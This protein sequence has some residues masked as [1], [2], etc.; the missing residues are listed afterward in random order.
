MSPTRDWRLSFTPDQVAHL[1]DPETLCRN[2]LRR[3]DP[4]LEQLTWMAPV[5][6][7]WIR[8][9][10]RYADVVDAD[11]GDDAAIGVVD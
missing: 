3:D 8:S 6:I 2:G 1:A 7:I 9:A 11:V 4:D 10:W 5:D